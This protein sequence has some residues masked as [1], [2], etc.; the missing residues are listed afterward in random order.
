[1]NYYKVLFYNGEMAV[2]LANSWRTAIK[3]AKSK[4]GNTL[5]IVRLIEE[6][7]DDGRNSGLVE[8]TVRKFKYA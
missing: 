2:V 8:K 7:H 4:I 5:S 3:K 1:M 6:L